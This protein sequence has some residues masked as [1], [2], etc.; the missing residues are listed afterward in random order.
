MRGEATN[1]DETVDMML[2]NGRGEFAQVENETEMVM[3]FSQAFIKTVQILANAVSGMG[4][5]PG[6]ESAP[7]GGAGGK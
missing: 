2:K 4:V 3:T 5:I 7:T 1:R 6:I